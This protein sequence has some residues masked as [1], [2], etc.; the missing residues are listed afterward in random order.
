[1][2]QNGFLIKGGIGNPNHQYHARAQVN[3][4]SKV[5]STLLT[6]EQRQE[7]EDA[8]RAHVGKSAARN[9]F[10]IRHGILLSREQIRHIAKRAELDPECEDVTEKRMPAAASFTRKP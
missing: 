7:L 9:M 3:Q 5:R 10:F 8:E 4:I 1:V 6:D 2:D